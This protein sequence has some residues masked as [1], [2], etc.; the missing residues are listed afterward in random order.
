[1]FYAV[2]F[3]HVTDN[4]VTSYGLESGMQLQLFN[5]LYDDDAYQ[6]RKRYI[7]IALFKY[8]KT[9]GFPE[10]LDN[11]TYIKT[12][13]IEIKGSEILRSIRNMD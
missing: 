12:F 8:R 2:G 4:S 13:K 11:D 7:I 10:T 3:D 1:M 6:W 5:Q 9:K